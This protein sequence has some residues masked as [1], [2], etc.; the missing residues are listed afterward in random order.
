MFNSKCLRSVIIVVLLLC[1]NFTAM[2]AKKAAEPKADKL[3]SLIPADSMF[4]VRLNNLDYTLGRIDQFLA[5]VSPMPIATSAMV[6]M[7]L[8]EILGTPDVNGVNMNGSFALFGMLSQ[9]ES[10]GDDFLSMII[11]VTNYKKLVSENPNI[12]PPDANGVS[13]ITGKKQGLFVQ[14]GDFALIKSPRSYNKIVALAKSLTAAEAKGLVSVLDPDEVKKAASEPVWIYG[15]VQLASKAFGPMLTGK[16]EE[17]KKMME[18]MKASGQGGVGNPAAVMNIYSGILDTL[19]KETKSVSAT[20]RPEPN[21]CDLKISVSAVPDTNMAKMFVTD[22]SAGQENKLLGYLKDGAVVNFGCRMNTPFFRQVNAKRIDLISS[23]AGKDM[24]VED[25]TKMKKLATDASDS[26]GGSAALSFSVDAGSKPPFVI[27]YVAEFSDADKFNKVIEE[28]MAMLNSGNFDEFYK[29]LGMKMSFEL[30]RGVDRYGDIS[31]DAAKLVMKS[32][33]PNTPQ[34][35]MINAM[36]GDGFNY[37]WA[38]VNKL[39]VCSVSSD[40]NSAIR[41]LIDEVKAGGPKQIAGEMKTALALLP[42]S[43]K[44]DCVGTYNFLRLFGMMTAFMPIPMPKMDIP[45]KSDIAFASKISN[46][47]MSVEIVLPKEHLME[48]SGF[49]QKMHQQQQQQWQQQ[50]QQKAPADSVQPSTKK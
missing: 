42:G 48:I 38:I 27:R 15:N 5:G 40:P 20:I 9:G 25:I 3:L 36:F 18:Q 4:C 45:T 26:F 17:M 2:A 34:G 8:A 16:I 47:K 7:Q 13:K 39:W 12:S 44:A 21:M 33:E 46:G 35:Q 32:T 22:A 14:A 41:Q 6:R 29:S 49:F 11:P 24:K 37:R 28:A 31:I 50:Q 43:D 19:M 30:K 23:M 1:L 10:V